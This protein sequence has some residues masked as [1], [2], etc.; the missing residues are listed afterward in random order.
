MRSA[1]VFIFCHNIRGVVLKLWRNSIVRAFVSTLGGVELKPAAANIKIALREG[2][3]DLMFAKFA[4][5]FQIQ[6]AFECPRPVHTRMRPGPKFEN[7]SISAKF[8]QADRRRRI[9]KN[10][11]ISLGDLEQEARHKID[12]GIISDTDRYPKP[13]SIAHITPVDNIF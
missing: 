11:F 8:Q 1:T 3:F 7:E 4:E 12:I 10:I 5:Y 2:H 6:I 9:G 13:D